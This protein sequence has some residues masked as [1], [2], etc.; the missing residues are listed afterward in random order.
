MANTATQQNTYKSAVN[1]T[2]TGL[3]RL[4]NPAQKFLKIS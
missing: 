2:L 1:P 3:F 4:R